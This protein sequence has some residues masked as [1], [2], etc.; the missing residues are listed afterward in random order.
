[1]AFFQSRI[2]RQLPASAS[3]Q[4]GSP[5]V[6][7]WRGHEAVVPPSESSEDRNLRRGEALRLLLVEDLAAFR[8]LLAEVG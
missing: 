5:P 1:M 6:V 3:G 8:R 4:D 2:G 7:V